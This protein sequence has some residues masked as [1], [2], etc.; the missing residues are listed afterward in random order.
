MRRELKNTKQH[1]TY[2][3]ILKLQLGL[4]YSYTIVPFIIYRLSLHK[5]RLNR[6]QNSS[7][8]C[9]IVPLHNQALT[10]FVSAFLLVGVAYW[11]AIFLKIMAK[12]I[13]SQ[14][15]E[16]MYRGLL[17]LNNCLNEMIDSTGKRESISQNSK[18]KIIEAY[19]SVQ[20]LLPIQSINEQLG[21]SGQKLS[22]WSKE[23]KCLA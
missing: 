16:S 7:T 20:G 2:I 21:L 15:Y 9:K 19:K 14:D 17:V 8:Y 18:S 22:R 5:Y 12:L 11:C 10:S 6:V 13:E 3:Q 23:K 4:N 1:P